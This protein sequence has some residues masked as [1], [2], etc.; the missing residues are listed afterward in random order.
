MSNKVSTPSKAVP[1]VAKNPIKAAINQYRIELAILFALVILVVSL[2]IIEPRFLMPA[3]IENVLSQVMVLGLIAIGQTF[4]ILTGGIDLS[5]GGIAAISTMVGA[6]VMLQWGFV[7]GVIAMLMVG[8]LV[9]TINGF[10]VS[11]I[12][13]APFIVTLATAS[14]AVSITYVISDGSTKT[15][16]PAEFAKLGSMKIFGTYAYLWLL[17][18]CY[19]L[20]HIFLTRAKYG[21]YLYAAGSNAEAARLAGVPIDRV[22]MF[23]YIVTGVLCAVAMM[24]EASRLGAIDPNTGTGFEMNTIAAV[25]IGGASLMGGRGTVVG[26]F[27]GILLIGVLSNGLNLL[28]VN[29]FWQGTALGVIMLLAVVLDRV[30]RIRNSKK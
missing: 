13:L 18:I 9:G 20:A 25:V 29:A 8:A 21:R 19:I 2:S 7:P 3:N 26:T 23:P 30:V 4:V 10:L 28:G 22:L 6:I 16:L 11:K 24:I 27:I 17:V 5:V 14:I 12:K 1:L 15:G